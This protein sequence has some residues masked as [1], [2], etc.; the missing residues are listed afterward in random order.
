MILNITIKEL[1]TLL[2][3][4]LDYQPNQLIKNITSLEQAQEDDV[5]I[6]LDR[7]D[8]SVFDALSL[9]K[10]KNCNASFIIAHKPVVEG[11]Q[12]IIVEDPLDAFQKI[13]DR[14]QAIRRTQDDYAP[15]PTHALVSPSA[16]IH[17][18]AIIHSGAIISANASIGAHCIIYSHVFI[19]QNCVIEDYVTVHPG[20]RILEDCIVGAGSIIHAN[21]VIGSDGFGYQVTSKG[22]RKIPQIGIVIIGKMAEIGAQCAIDRASF[23][24]T[25]IGNGVKI[26]NAVHIAHNV[27][28]GDGSAIL[29]QTGIAGSAKIGR[30]CQIGGQVAIKNDITIGDGAKIVSKSG[31]LSNVNPGQT[32]SGIPAIEFGLWKRIYAT[33]LRLPEWS[34]LVASFKTAAEYHN[35]SLWGKIK[36]RLWG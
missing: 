33:T 18:T 7:G 25:I 30:G 5:A 13:V 11:K 36:K 1:S 34:K 24:K 20:V 27:I 8:A 9:E 32:V 15:T 26:D 4:T 3:I 16:T 22:L 23:D 12:Y 31:V 21:A 28:I 6:V 2:N 35:L 10:I 14:A 17:P 29:A 19:G